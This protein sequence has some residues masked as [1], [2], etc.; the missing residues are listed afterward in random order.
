MP[1]A[2]DNDANVAA[3]AEWQ[4]APGAERATS[5]MLTLGTGS[6]AGSSSTG[7]LPRR[8]R[9]RRRARA[10][11]GRHRRAAVPGLLHRAAATSRRWRPGAPPTAV[12]QAVLGPDADARAR[13]R[14]AHAG[15]RA[16]DRGARGSA[17]ISAPAIGTLRQHLQPRGDRRRRRLRARPPASC[18]S[19]RRARSCAAEA[20]SP[21][22]RRRPHRPGR[23][24][25]R[26]GRR[27][28]GA[29]RLRVARRAQ[30]DARGL[31]DADRQP[32]R[33]H[34]ARARR[35][36]ARRTSCCARTRA[37]RA[38]CSTGTAS[39]RQLLSYHRHNE[40]AR[41]AEILPR[42]AAGARIALVSDAGLPGVND[43]GA[44]LVARRAT[45]GSEVTVLPGAVGG[46]DRAR[47]E[48]ARGRAVPVPRVPAA[49][50]EA[51]SG[52][53][54]RSSP[55]GRSA[56]VAFESP[57]RL[58][59]VA[60]VAR[61]GARR[62]APGRGLPRADEALRGGR[63]GS[64]AEVAA[65]FAEPPKGEIALVLGPAPAPAAEED[66]GARRRARAGRGGRPAPRA[67]ELVARLTGG[68]ARDL[69]RRSL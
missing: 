34:A 48:R 26:G 15:D 56:V 67:A 4:R 14:R 61:G 22:P 18:C 24:R 8:A 27:R 37:I 28:R 17:A 64:A 12:A 43:P 46:R 10:H 59:R 53:C 58:P 33:R 25:A 54:G 50:R 62:S 20:L 65:R 29:R 40:A 52:R 55:R 23:A 2:I 21:G 42:L 66:A 44:R 57:Q 19:A 68:S 36:R 51:R 38:C 63:R 35:A 11:G 47:R 5:I 3:V 69:Y 39:A 41:T 1:S 32:R 16:G 60:R 30:R 7:A 49:R 31:R 6:A 9:C 45:P 13:R